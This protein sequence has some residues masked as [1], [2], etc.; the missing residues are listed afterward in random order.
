MVAL[1][2]LAQL[3]GLPLSAIVEAV[4][5][6]IGRKRPEAV[7]ASE[8]AVLLGSQQ[9]PNLDLPKLPVS[10]AK[11]AGR[12]SITGNE[13]TGLGAIKGGVRFVA[14]YPIT[15]ATEILEWMATALPQCGGL[16][17]QAEDELASINMV[18][19]ASFGGK[20]SLTATSGP[21]LSLMI[22][23]LGLAIAS[24]TPLV[25]VDVMRSGPSTGIATKSEQSDLN[26]AVYGLHGDAPHVVTAPLSVS[27]CLLTAQW[28]VHLAESLQTAVI[29]LSDQSI[30]QARV[31]IDRPEDDGFETIR[32]K[33]LELVEAYE[34]YALTESGVS[35]M[36][37]PGTA[38]GQ[39]TADGLT[40]NAKGMPSSQA[41]D[42]IAQLNKR[43][44]KID[45]F[46]FGAHWAEI[47]G[48][49]E[50]A[51][52]TWGSSSEPLREAIAL[53]REQGVKVKLVA[54]RLISPPQPSRLA[55]ALAGVKRVLVIEQNYSGQFWRYLLAHYKL[56]VDVVSV[57][58][59]G[60]L[61]IRPAQALSIILEGAQA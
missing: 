23:T 31:V 50:L 18:M 59:P 54:M 1:G 8:S 42:H 32:L 29:M 46:D 13:M 58:L 55:A 56:P 43:Q 57:P 38:G 11:P 53:A 27:D 16:M 60:P 20:P 41:Q 52:L 47:D 24:E 6:E 49:G 34:R 36:S 21:G 44:R 33:P 19:G 4:A 39:Y 22:E 5:K 3:L 61:L 45:R 9:A 40:H 15:P 48:E 28:S 25:V 7:V 17:L 37:L 10:A 30:G 12:W 14:G 2:A 35:P 26:I 51:V